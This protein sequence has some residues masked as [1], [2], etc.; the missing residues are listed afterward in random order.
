MIVPSFE[1]ERALVGA[2]DRIRESVVRIDGEGVAPEGGPERWA[3]GSGLVWDRQG[4][5]VTNDHVTRGARRLRVV[6]AD[7]S[8]HEGRSVGGDSLTDV[9]L[10]RV[11]GANLPAAATGDSASLQVGQFAIAMGSSLGLPG[12]PTASVGIVSALHRPLPGADFVPE[13]LVQT[14]AAINPGNS[15]GPLVDLAGTVIGLNTANVPTAQGVGFAVPVNTVRSV[16]RELLATGRIRRPWIGIHGASIDANVARA[17][18]LVRPRGVLVAGVDPDSPAAAAGL[19]PGDVIIR[20]GSVG[21]RSFA[22]LVV[23]M[24]PAG[25]GADLDLGVARGR[26]E[27]RRLVTLRERSPPETG[28]PT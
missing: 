4:L 27:F 23:A 13:G 17:R 16:S 18:G 9:A 7:G 28:A 25:I 6:L 10:V 20:A 8:T 15:G 24:A 5:V 26:R 21:I 14:D 2:V 11:D 19:Q 1:M 22:D 3:T 12:G